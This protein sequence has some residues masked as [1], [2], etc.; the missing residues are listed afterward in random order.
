MDMNNE[1]VGLVPAA[2]EGSRMYPFAR[3]VPKEMYPILG[4][5]VIEHCIENLKEGGINKI[6]MIVGHQKGSIMDYLGDGSFFDVNISYIYQMKR[7]GLGHAILQ[8]D[9]WINTT[10]VTLLGDSF[11]EPKHE[12]NNLLNLHREKKPIATVL[13]FEVSDPKGYGVV[14]FKNLENSRGELEKLFEKPNEEQAKEFEFNDKY[15]ALCGCYVFESKIF[16]YIKK[17]KPGAKNEIQITD[18]IQLALDSGE[19]IY[20]LVLKGKYIDIGKWDT[21]LR[22]ESEMIKNADIESSIKDREEITDRI[23]SID[24]YD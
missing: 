10:F 23:R 2:G 18:A 24:K 12:I 16:D 11:I 4:K 17:T 5:S 7:G 20:G 6:Y 13:L 8:G 14:K 19:R 9:K 21:V 3:A 1:I 15:Y 22:V